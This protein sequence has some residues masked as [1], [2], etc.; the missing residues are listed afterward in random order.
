VLRV[1]QVDQ[2]AREGRV[3]GI[4]RVCQKRLVELKEEIWAKGY[5][6]VPTTV[7]TRQYNDRV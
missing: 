4:R 5:C 1:C 2:E 6:I 3:R 7:K